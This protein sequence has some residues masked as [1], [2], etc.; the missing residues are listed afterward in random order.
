MLPRKMPSATSPSPQSSGCRKL[1]GFVVLGRR[2]LIRDG[3][4]GRSLVLRFV[5]AMSAV[6]LR[7]RDEPCEPPGPGRRRPHDVEPAGIPAGLQAVAGPVPEQH[8]A[9][10]EQPV[11]ALVAPEVEAPL[12]G[13][14]ALERGSAG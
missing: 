7:R 6:L 12:P 3:V 1:R 10:A 13:G 4:F 14:C 9:D 5:R 2:F 11:E 8:E